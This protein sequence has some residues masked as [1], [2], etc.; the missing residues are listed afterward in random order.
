MESN[1]KTLKWLI[2]NDSSIF[3][4]ILKK[5]KINNKEYYFF[6]TVSVKVEEINNLRETYRFKFEFIARTPMP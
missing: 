6:I 5:K 2:I 4:K 1:F 3:V